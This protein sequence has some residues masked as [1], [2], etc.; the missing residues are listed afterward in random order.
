MQPSAPYRPPLLRRPSAASSGNGTPGRCPFLG[1]P[2]DPGTSLAFASE[3][4][5]CFRSRFP[6]PVSSIHQESYCLSAQYTTCPVY[7]QYEDEAAASAADNS[8]VALVPLTAVAAAAGGASAAWASEPAMPAVGVG[9]PALFPSPRPLPPAPAP[10]AP[11]PLFPLGE[12]VYPDFPVDPGPDPA[13]A[14]PPRRAVAGE[15]NGRAV[16][17]GVA[18]LALLVLAGW[19]WLNFLGNRA[20]ERTTSG[21]VVS[22]PTAAATPEPDGAAGIAVGL[23]AEQTATALAAAP[24]DSAQVTAD[25][26]G[27]SAAPDAGQPLL[28]SVAMTATALFA[29]PVTAAEC[30]PP[31]WWVRYV[32]QEGDTVEALALSRGILA[33]ELIVANCLTQPEL[34]TGQQLFLPPVG[35]IVLLPGAAEATATATVLPAPGLPTRA[36]VLFP[37]ATLPIIIVIPTNQPN[38]EETVAPTREAPPERATPIPPATI[39]PTATPPGFATSAPP[40]V[41]PTRT[42]PGNAPT[43][44]PPGSMPTRTPPGTSATR[45]PPP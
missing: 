3:A 28:D 17:A 37:T 15:V 19:A 39:R 22:L 11:E 10:V 8:G 13:T 12:S 36:P 44:T 21:T 14:R 7:R 38:V 9:G 26:A 16:L 18:L 1:T 29:G 33:E 34:T 31:D 20:D 30:G 35:V 25:A 27:G 41:T 43:R 5:H 42:P 23:G 2:A 40:G 6:V 4:N 24:V 32:V 45:T